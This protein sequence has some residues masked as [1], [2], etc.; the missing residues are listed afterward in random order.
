MSA[1]LSIEMTEMLEFVIIIYC[2]G[3]FVFFVFL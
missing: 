2:V 3:K 1:D